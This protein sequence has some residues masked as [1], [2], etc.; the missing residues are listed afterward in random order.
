M[1]PARLAPMSRRSVRRVAQTGGM[2]SA[3]GRR[4]F[5]Q[6]LLGAVPLL[7]AGAAMD[8][9]TPLAAAAQSYDPLGVMPLGT[10][11][12]LVSGAGGNVVVVSGGDGVLLVNG[13][14]AEHSVA[15]L[16]AIKQGTGG[17][18]VEIL[19]N[20][21]WHPSH[22]GSNAALAAT[23]TRI[24]A[25]EHTKQYLGAE[26]FVDWENRTYKPL[27][28]RALPTQTF[29]AAGSMIFGGVRVEYAPLG[30]AH[31]DGDIYVFLPDANVLVVG[32]V[33]SVGKYP[34]ADYTTGG[35]LGGLANATKTLVDLANDDTRVVPAHGPVQTR[36][37]LRA[38]HEMLVAMRDRLS[39]MMRQGL[40]AQEM[41]AAGVTKEFDA[42][43]G[44]PELFLSTSYRGLWL[45]VRELGGIV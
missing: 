4:V 9:A 26:L 6:S 28:A 15:L 44:D 29:Q 34:I 5:L 8:L 21:D 42:T 35:W 38:Q 40:G 2:A 45:H 3:P 27:P 43:W 41:R 32:D 30:Q 17:R 23:G 33:L 13:G 10:G 1:F 36:A 37:D 14:A 24:I 18:P 12:R 16:G 25:H 31:T 7:A 19:F 11:A 20:T 39:K 22:S